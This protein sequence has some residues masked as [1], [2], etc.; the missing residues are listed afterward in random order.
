MCV[1]FH[2][3][4]LLIFLLHGGEEG[5]DIYIYTHA[6]ARLYF[7]QSIRNKAFLLHAARASL[8]TLSRPPRCQAQNDVL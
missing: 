8:S 3:I 2:C 6:Y 1:H 5:V 7:L 4:H